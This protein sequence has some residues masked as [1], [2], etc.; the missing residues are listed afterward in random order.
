MSKND[1][2]DAGGTGRRSSRVSRT[3]LQPAS[4]LQITALLFA[5]LLYAYYR[6]GKRLA[7]ISLRGS[8][9][10]ERRARRTDQTRRAHLLLLFLFSCNSRLADLLIPT[11]FNLLRIRLEFTL[12]A[13]LSYFFLCEFSS[14]SALSLPHLPF[15]THS[16]PPPLSL[17]A[18]FDACQPSPPP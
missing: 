12:V 8:E 14:S 13:S 10:A 9:G 18:L 1:P 2:E 16:P 11:R 4:S 15:C 7:S 17:F 5:L 3:S 6:R